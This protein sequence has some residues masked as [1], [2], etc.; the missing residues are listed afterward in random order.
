M[1]VL[2]RLIASGPRSGVSGPNSDEDVEHFLKGCLRNGVVDHLRRQGREISGGL[3]LDL[4]TGTEA[5]PDAHLDA[6]RA[7]ELLMWARTELY[8]C[9][10]P[11][12]AKDLA[13]H[14]SDAT[15]FCEA[16]GQL[17]AIAE[18]RTTFSEILR[19]APDRTDAELPDR[20]YQRHCRARKRVITWIEANLTKLLVCDSK[21]RALCV[22]ISELQPRLASR[23]SLRDRL[24][25]VFRRRA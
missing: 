16:I 11:A 21:R 9:I 23:R 3:D 22:A 4:L 15:A 7:A 8:E 14:S 19:A 1:E 5:S 10:V 25:K 17:R 18:G 13:R 6:E 24:F 2:A 12:I 20:L